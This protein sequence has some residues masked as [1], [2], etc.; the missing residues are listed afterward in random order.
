M[1]KAETI[2]E[3]PPQLTYNTM[4]RLPKPVGGHR[5]IGL[6]PDLLRAYNKCHKAD[7]QEWLNKKVKDYHYAVAGRSSEQA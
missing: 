3:L 7:Q 1:H 6:L 4:P 5:L 2:G